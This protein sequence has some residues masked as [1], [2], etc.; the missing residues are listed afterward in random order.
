VK[1]GS[2]SLLAVASVKATDRRESRL[3]ATMQDNALVITESGG[4]GRTARL[5][6]G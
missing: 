6:K 3:T 1:P 2:F 4:C 5:A